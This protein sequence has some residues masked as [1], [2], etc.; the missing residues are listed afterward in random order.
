MQPISMR[1][2]YAQEILL[3]KKATQWKQYIKNKQEIILIQIH[4]E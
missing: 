1:L 3:T 2:Y 4:L